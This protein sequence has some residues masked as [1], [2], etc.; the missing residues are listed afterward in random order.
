MSQSLI[1]AVAGHQAAQFGSRSSGTFAA[2]GGSIGRSEDCDW[3]LG[4][5]G[6]S[7]V[8]AMVRYLN[9]IYFIEDRSTNGMLL[10]GAPLVKGEPSA[11]TDGDRLLIDTFEVEVHL[12]DAGAGAPAPDLLAPAAPAAMGADIDPLDF[13]LSPPAAPLPAR[14]SPATIPADAELIPDAVG[15][16]ALDPLSFLGPGDPDS[17]LLSGA[18]TGNSGSSWNHT[19]GTQDHFHPP[20]TNER[21][22]AN[23]LPENWDLTM[24]DFSAPAA[25]PA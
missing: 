19:A 18:T 24:G 6:V 5:S 21:R 23:Q 16:G 3:V 12:R 9:G 17:G 2:V 13:G 25:A 22:Q 15:S 14:P 4:A 1:L 11:L 7:R 10:N 8:H 20:M